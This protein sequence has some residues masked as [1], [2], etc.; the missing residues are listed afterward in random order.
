MMES[1]DEAAAFYPRRLAAVRAEY[2]QVLQRIA[3]LRNGAAGLLAGLA[4]AVLG[5]IRRSVWEAL[6]PGWVLLVILGMLVALL[7]LYLQSLRVRDRLLRLVLHYERARERLA[8]TAVQ[9][10]GGGEEFRESKHLYE[11]DLNLLG[12]GSLFGRLDT[13]RTGVGQRGLARLLLQADRER[14]A[15]ELLARRAAIQELT[16]KNA[17][18]EQIALLG[19]SSLQQV[20]A[21]FFDGWLKE[22][23]PELPRW[24]RGSLLATSGLLLVL[25]GL[26]LAHVLP[27]EVARPN[28]LCVFVVQGALALRVRKQVVGLL[29]G[30][31][32]LSNQVAIFREGLGLLQEGSF[33]AERLRELQRIS[34]MPNDTTTLLGRL[35]SQLV[36]VEQRTKQWFLVPSLLFCIGTH[37][38]L[39]IAHWKRAYAAAMEGWLE[40]WAEFE[41]LHAL[42]T[43]AYE[44][45]EYVYPEMLAAG[46]AVFTATAMAHPLLPEGAVA[47]D[48]CLDEQNRLYLISGSN[49]AG[50]STLLRA[51]GVNAVLANT[52]A[53]IRARAARMSP[54]VLGASIALTDSLAEGRSKFLAE[55]ERLH[56]I[57]GAAQGD[58]GRC[59]LFLIDEIFSGTN[60]LDRRIAAEAVTRTLIAHGAIGALSTHDLTLTEMAA[61]EELHAT[62]V[63]MGS[64][65]A[66]DPLAFDYRLKPGVNPSSNA[67]AIL[68]M[69][70]IDL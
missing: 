9:V 45:P 42:A 46:T 65:E 51:I 70:G 27:W 49:M 61:A 37:A 19:D 1:E 57:L 12:P 39:S 2:E 47:N 66:G 21:H 5:A 29:D 60:S 28:L 34:A 24:L 6:V 55:V 35:E 7:L 68:R 58:D 4:A 31:S 40:A 36:I 64:P 15:E 43:F 17:L 48:L 38:A 30:S 67:L 26:A 62:N 11:H 44:H 59:V 54:M 13:V 14:T 23:P 32:R 33:N 63:H 41:A 10:G 8:G 3:W 56:A 20:P 69:M 18:R 25:T 53:P 22:V 50:K 16:P 52:G